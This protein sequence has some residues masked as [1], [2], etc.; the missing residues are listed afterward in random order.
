MPQYIQVGNDVVEFPDGMSE[1]QITAALSGMS[2]SAPQQEDTSAVTGRILARR[3]VMTPEQRQAENLAIRRDITT[4]LAQTALGIAAAPALGAAAGLFGAT[5]ALAPVLSSAGFAGRGGAAPTV[6]Q[7]LFGGAVT[8]AAGAGAGE[9][10]SPEEKDFGQAA[11]TGAVIGAAIP[12][13][14]APVV[15]KLAQGSGWL[16]DA[17]AGKLGDVKAAKIARDVAG[18]DINAIKAANL[19]ASQGETAGQAAAGIDNAA[20]QALDNLSRT[21][22]TGSWWTRRLAVQEAEVTDALNRLAG[23]T[24][25]SGSSAVQKSAKAALNKITTPIREQAFEQVRAGLTPINSKDVSARLVSKLSDPD[26]AT[27]RDAAG[28]I[29]RIEELI[30]SQTDDAGNISPEALYAI[31]KNGVASAIA[32]LNPGA[33]DSARKRL[34]Q[35]VLSDIKP[36]IDEVIVS[37]G[38]T[39]F[40]NYLE[41]FEKG[42]KAIEQKQMADYARNLYVSGDKK[43]FVNLIKGNDP[44][45]VES[46]FGPGRNDFIKEMGGQRPKSPALEFLKLADNVDKDL[47]VSVLAKM[48][49]KPLADIF[50]ENQAKMLGIPL[51]P[52]LSAKVTIA[53]EG[54][55]EFEQKVNRATLKALENAMRSGKSANELLSTLPTSERN[56]VLNVL[57]SSELWNPVVQR[58]L[59]AAAISSAEE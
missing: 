57:S 27:N 11:T 26:I 47:R 42:M 8:G 32:D 2:A 5:R 56:K 37:A 20:W 44:D 34:A 10:I 52:L 4:P 48:G 23:G 7:R 9:I 6:A 3:R 1:A 13:V 58:A 16:Y 36:I 46:I 31:R 45:A 15:K 18:G 19:A 53:R 39:K 40:P 41:T 28:A 22:N 21:S 33:S 51:P 50:A 30:A 35:T 29:R 38:G 17:L 55:K 54:L 25:I 43:G 49:G 24:S 12:G 14:A 59:P